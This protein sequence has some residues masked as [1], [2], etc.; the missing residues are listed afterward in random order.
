[1]RAFAAGTGQ[2]D[3]AAAQ[4]KRVG[5]SQ[6]SGELVVFGVCQRTHVQGSFHA[7]KPRASQACSSVS[8]LGDIMDKGRNV[9]VVCAGPSCD[10][11]LSSAAIH[12]LVRDG[13]FS[14]CW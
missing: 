8:V 10:S 3:L 6:T 12:P 5:R 4:G 11:D 13:H 9:D 14:A 7:T 2:Q 1:M